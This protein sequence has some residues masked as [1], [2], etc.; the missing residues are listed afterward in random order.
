MVV[1]L[2]I[3]NNEISFSLP[4]IC[5]YVSFTYF[6]HVVQ[7]YFSFFFAFLGPYPRHKEVPTL[8]VESELK[9]LAYTTA[10]AKPDLRWVCDLWQHQILNPLSQA[11]DWT[12]ILTDTSQVLNPL[13]HSGNSS[14]FFFISF[15]LWVQEKIKTIVNTSK[16]LK[17]L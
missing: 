5:S 12:H 11:R 17:P 1:I 4:W 16:K 14:I 8:G 6:S 13:S 10:T 15:R 3:S 7:T 9:L 2:Y